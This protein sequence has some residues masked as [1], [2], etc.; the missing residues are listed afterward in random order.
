MLTSGDAYTYRYFTAD[1]LT[2]EIIAEVPFKGVSYERALKGAGSFSGTIGVAAETAGL[3]VYNSTLPGKTALY[4][5]RNNVCVWGGIIWSRSYD[6]VSKKLNVSASEFTSLLYHRRAWRTWT[7]KFTADL[8]VSGGVI[9]AT[10]DDG[11]TFTLAEDSTAYII[12]SDVSDFAYNGYYQLTAE[13][14]L[15]EVTQ[16]ATLTMSA[17]SVATATKASV[18]MPDG[19]YEAVSIEV[20]AN[21]YDYVRSLISALSVDF[22]GT[23]F[24]NGEIEPAQNTTLRINQRG[25]SD[26]VATITANAAVD[27]IPG[28]EF[29]VRNVG[30]NFDGYHT[31]DTVD[32]A[33][34]T[35][36]SGGGSI[37]YANT[38]SISFR[39][40][41]RRLQGGI[42]LITT[43]APH[44]LY[45]GQYVTLSG[46]DNPLSSGN[47]YDGTFRVSEVPTPTTFKYDTGYKLNEDYVTMRPATVTTSSL[48]G[49]TITGATANGSSITYTASNNFAVG[50][51][52]TVTGVT[53]SAFNVDKERIIA[54]TS[55]TFTVGSAIPS[56]TTYSSGGSATAYALIMARRATD[57]VVDLATSEN[58]GLGS[59][60]SSVTVDVSG[61]NDTVTVVARGL[62]AN[63]ATLTTAETHGFSV[64]NPVTVTG[65]TD[66]A[67]T[68]TGSMT[69]SGNTATFTVDL[70][71][72][73]NLLVGNT[74]T[75]TDVSDTYSISGYAFT[76]AT[77]SLVFTTSAAH[78]I[79]NGAKVKVSGL[80]R[81]SVNCTQ[82]RRLNK[83]VTLTAPANHNVKANDKIFVSGYKTTKTFNISRII[84]YGKTSTSPKVSNYSLVIAKFTAKHNMAAGVYLTTS[85][86]SPIG[87]GG[88][89]KNGRFR[90]TRIISDYEVEYDDGIDYTGKSISVTS[91]GS[92]DLE[93]SY[94][95]NG[96]WTVSAVTSTSIKYTSTVDED[97]ALTND[98]TVVTVADAAEGDY[99]VTAVSTN[100]FTVTSTAYS[101]DRT[102]TGLSG[103][104]TVPEGIFNVTNANVLSTPSATSFTFSKST[105]TDTYLRTNVAQKTITGNTAILS[106]YFN[107]TDVIIT[108]VT[109]KS[110]SFVVS[111]GVKKTIEN[112]F[113]RPTGLATSGSPFG[114]TGISA[115]VT[116]GAGLRY[117]KSGTGTLK[118]TRVFGAAVGTSEPEI[119]FG[120]YGGYTG[121]SDILFEFS[122]DG[123][124]TTQTPPINFRG[125]EV[126]SIGE[127]L[128][129][130][131]DI[132]NGFEYRVDCVYDDTT[133][134]FR[135]I[136]TLLPI[137]P[138]SLQAYLT[139]L[140]G[141]ALYLG[142][143]AP[144]SAFGADRLVFQFPGN[145]SDLSIDESAENSAT[146][147]F[148]VGNV[149]DLGDDASQPYAVAIAKDLLYP[150]SGSM[151]AW[152]LLDDTHSDQDIYD[153][154]VLYDYAQRYLAEARPP[155]TKITVS[156]N[157]SITPGIGTYSPGDWCTLIID[158][159][160]IRQRLSNDLEPRG[161]VIVRK[162]DGLSVTVPDGATFPEKISL[163]LIPEWQADQVGK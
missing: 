108:K 149:G 143:A 145:I 117:T 130:Y 156:V 8:R 75:I 7:N 111:P 113:A 34:I 64:G 11:M 146:R 163:T 14:S 17:T 3:D 158:D 19:T 77:S 20:H 153:E 120:T 115:T 1:L 68:N 114:G 79:A 73:H 69:I 91:P 65:I 60:G 106:P 150:T 61:I 33:V 89:F 125:Y 57:N 128:D 85:W 29:R 45:V 92:A 136:F 96:W 16:I 154:D 28:Q 98:S 42:A 10:I 148:M 142:Q 90:V 26:G 157:G 116:A 63:V 49:K 66:L 13:S 104:V 50:Q 43:S 131:S 4:I 86:T 44:G 110:F 118:T 135:R 72:G 35:Y 100:T 84:K 6:V 55:S 126:R 155:D 56:T 27:L 87:T 9:T 18:T 141:G 138:E 67:A 97:I 140:P 101:V 38:T 80:E 134:K 102:R 24:P 41:S 70:K 151:T 129:K 127:E 105:A 36:E 78:N 133:G 152:P 162:I 147:F 47:L 15:D 93:Y 160:F 31:V 124:S 88:V 51:Y 12:M 132:I 109:P 159:E 53:P 76:F 144:P 137:L 74:V 94:G 83:V 37:S 71:N 112:G 30:P 59:V 62:V 58:H 2:N 22:H 119:H 103:T 121:N 95:I 122:S 40:I 99:D 81:R 32:G 5:M 107:K 82:V 21:T 46:F 48:S 54:A 139:T 161:D 23:N 39:A 52:V 25:V 123:Y